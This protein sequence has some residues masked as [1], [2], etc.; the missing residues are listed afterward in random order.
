MKETYSISWHEY[1]T[2]WKNTLITERS[3]KNKS[4]THSIT[5]EENSTQTNTKNE[6]IYHSVWVGEEKINKQEFPC[7]DEDSNTEMQLPFERRIK[8]SVLASVQN[9]AFN[10]S[11]TTNE[12]Y[13]QT[14]NSGSLCKPS[15]TMLSCEKKPFYY[16][17]KDSFKE[18]QRNIR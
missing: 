4:N 13:T 9:Q 14:D 10:H 1:F 3:I 16:S 18:I 8:P 11:P 5:K 7:S 12:K 15:H 6:H 2:T 17:S